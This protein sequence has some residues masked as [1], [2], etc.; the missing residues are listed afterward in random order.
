MTPHSA[1]TPGRHPTCERRL[2]TALVLNLGIVVVQVAAGLGAHSLGLLADA[3]HNLAGVAA[4]SLALVAVRMSTRRPTAERSFGFH[5]ST[6]LAAQ[7]NAGAV[8]TV[9]ALICT[10]RS[11]ASSTRCRCRCT[12]SLWWR[13]PRWRWWPTSA[14]RAG[15]TTA[16]L[17]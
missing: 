11:G 6:V 12:A 13:S 4:V 17:T 15:S 14:P 7:A 2:R 8:L 9:S 5:R 1:T 3:G 10:P 16:V